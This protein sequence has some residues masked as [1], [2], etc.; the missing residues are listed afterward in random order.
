MAKERTVSRSSARADRHRLYERSVQDV[1]TEV[2]LLKE[3]FYRA[4]HR[5]ARSLREDFSGTANLAC[6]WVKSNPYH[7]AVAVDNDPEVLEWG[8]RHHFDRLKPGQQKRVQLVRADVRHG[9]R[10]PFDLVVALNFSYWLFRDRSTLRDYF[11]T[12]R[13]A[14]GRDGLLI[15]DAYGGADARRLVRERRDMGPFT[16][17][18]DQADFDPITGNIS[19]HIHFKFRDGSRIN[20]AFSYEWRLW[21]L[22]ELRELLSEAGFARSRVLWQGTDEQSGEGNGDYHVVER[23]DADPAW[24]AYIEADPR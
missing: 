22:P 23:G 7:R 3:F 21:T 8:R 13:R 11:S 15:I 4:R 16:Y 19:C 1:V 17:I 9:P 10:G 2:G 5:Q 12:V 18:W 6:A 24:I 20:R 14:L